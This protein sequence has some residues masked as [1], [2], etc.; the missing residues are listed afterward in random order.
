M[1]N[2]A[3]D[4]V[5]LVD[6]DTNLLSAMRR[7]LH[8]KFAI[9]TA[10]SAAEGF[11]L[12]K[13]SGPYAVIICD[14]QMPVCNG[15]QFLTKTM[16][17]A[18]HSIRLMLTGSLDQDTATRAIN[19][20]QVYRFLKK[21]YDSA[22]LEAEINNALST[23]RVQMAEKELLE[24][25]LVG[26]VTVLV[27]IITA[28]HPR[29]FQLAQR[30]REELNEVCHALNYDYSWT[31]TMAALLLPLGMLLNTT[32]RPEP[33]TSAA[34]AEKSAALL[35]KIPR[36]AVV[37]DIITGVALPIG[38]SHELPG[39][40]IP[41]SSR[42]L[43]ILYDLHTLEAIGKPRSLALRMLMN[44]VGVYDARI[45]EELAAHY[46]PHI[47]SYSEIKSEP[48]VRVPRL[49]LTETATK[50][51][52]LQLNMSIMVSVS[53]LLVGDELVEPMMA[54]DG[55]LLLD[56][57]HIITE[58]NL[59]RLNALVETRG[60]REPICIKVTTEDLAPTAAAA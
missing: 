23:Y 31:A 11:A 57:G 38:R 20:A 48:A 6:D 14:M 55:S 25:T 56:P 2:N 40:E 44:T 21:P 19:Q 59:N 33:V 36:L 32:S 58:A 35:R 28:A 1:T 52:E 17:L 26:S 4:K 18:P 37:S 8:N 29:E 12:L 27:E 7:Q 22:L 15:L 42:L 34:I 5:L 54:M 50:E 10:G 47:V 51:E 13:N 60:I 53:E 41:Q 49:D 24:K 30:V 9:D 3:T 45:L 43:R 16:E 46:A 39:G